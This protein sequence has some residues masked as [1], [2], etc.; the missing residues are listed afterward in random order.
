M[1]NIIEAIINIVNNPILEIRNHYLGRNRANNVGEALETFVK[2]A[3]ANLIIAT[4]EQ[5]R[6]KRYN[7]VFS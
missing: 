4:D 3:F 7:E 6:I 5:V 2:D 1:T